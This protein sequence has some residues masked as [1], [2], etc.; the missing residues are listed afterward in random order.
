MHLV[1]TLRYGTDEEVEI[2]IE[3][4]K[5][6]SSPDDAIVHLHLLLSKRKH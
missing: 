5:Q 6:G 2:F 1:H 4:T 3:D